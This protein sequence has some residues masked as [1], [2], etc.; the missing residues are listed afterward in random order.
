VRPVPVI[1]REETTEVLPEQIHAYLRRG[2]GYEREQVG[3]FLA[4]FTPGTD[5]PMRNYAIPDDQANPTASDVAALIAC[6]RQRRLK[7]RLEYLSEAAPAVEPALRQASFVVEA[8]VPVMAIR[9]G[10]RPRPVVVPGIDVLMAVDAADHADAI[11]VAAEAYGEPAGR[12]PQ[13]MIEARLA[14]AAAGGGVALARVTSG[15]QAVG[16]GLYPVPQGGAT[17][18]AAVG[19]S[20]SHRSRGVAGALISRL[21][22]AAL[23]HGV[24]LVW[25]TAENPPEQHAAEAAGLINTESEMLHIS[26][27]TDPAP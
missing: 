4:T 9:Q 1:D 21:A 7:P 27:P 14:M 17:E 5:H 19:V 2:P 3:P 6:Y 26:L 20:A 23:D 11:V 12:P 10:Q 13:P 16:S 15:G 8:R 24:D 25:L 18:I 22:P